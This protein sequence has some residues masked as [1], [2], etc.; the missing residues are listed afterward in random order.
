MSAPN[1][2]KALSLLP[3]CA[4]TGIGS[5]PH[6]QLEMGLQMGLQVDIPYLPQL[7]AGAP[8][9]LMIPAALDGLPGLGVDAEGV[10]TVDLAAWEGARDPFSHAIEAALQSDHLEPFE[11]SPQASRAFR[12]FLWE[13]EN[14]KLA[15]AKV[16]IAGPCTVRWVARASDGRPASEIAALDQ[17]IFRLLLAKSLAL[18]KAV[19]RAGATPLLYLDEPG[20]YALDRRDARHLVA[21]QEL[22]M[23]IVALRRE[24][25]LVG[26]HCCSNTDW[27]AILE[28]GLDLV[29]LDVR[30]SLDALLEDREA[31]RRFLSTG[32]TLS[33]GIVPTDL[34][35]SYAVQDLVDSVE[36]SLRA[37]LG[38]SF[39]AALSHV[40]LTPACGLAMRSVMDAERIFSELR[41]A[42]RAVRRLVEVEP[43]P[44]TAPEARA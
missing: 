6:T 2:R 29:S 15:L 1:V 31:F 16:Q 35:A 32:A 14:R 11:P 17:Q 37:T 42:Q 44:A 28:L 22:R 40:L 20:L 19:R 3:S 30:L 4:T 25:A 8:S 27:A 24:G 38:R 9:E 12:P 39:T 41:D 23:L 21:L 7:P 26:L 34:S 33:L 18:V 10:T 36:A 5:L 13:V 43:P